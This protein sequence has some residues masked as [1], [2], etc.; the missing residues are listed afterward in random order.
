MVSLTPLM[1]TMG[2]YLIRDAPELHRQ[3]GS[4]GGRPWGLHR[5]R[6]WLMQT[7][8]SGSRLRLA[9]W[10]LW[11][12]IK[13]P[14]EPSRKTIRFPVQF[15]WYGRSRKHGMSLFLE[16]ANSATSPSDTHND[17][18]IRIVLAM[19]ALVGASVYGSFAC[20]CVCAGLDWTNTPLQSN[21]LQLMYAK[22][23][24]TVGNGANV[25]IRI[26]R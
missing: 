21:E 8:K 16:I 11:L 5:F 18:G 26:S 20:V 13:W 2:I 1:L 23:H 19:W 14:M 12:S 9:H 17:E 10:H 25:A 6:K 4:L 3:F 24:C 7:T 15:L 22:Q